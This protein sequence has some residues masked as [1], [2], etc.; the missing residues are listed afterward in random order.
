MAILLSEDFVAS[1]SVELTV[2][3]ANDA[4]QTRYFSNYDEAMQWLL[5][6]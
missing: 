6:K 5:S 2:N 1:L 4:F 3:E